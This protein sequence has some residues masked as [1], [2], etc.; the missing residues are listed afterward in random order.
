MGKQV[1]EIIRLITIAKDP[2]K[3]QEE[4]LAAARDCS[5]VIAS[6]GVGEPTITLAKAVLSRVVDDCKASVRATDHFSDFGYWRRFPLNS[7]NKLDDANALRH[8]T[9]LTCA[10]L[11]WDGGRHLEAVNFFDRVLEGQPTASAVILACWNMEVLARQQ[12]SIQ[13]VERALDLLTSRFKRILDD[14]QYEA[15]V[16]HLSG[17]LLL[18]RGRFSKNE[19]LGYEKLGVQRLAYA[20]SLW[21]AYSACYASSFAEYGDFLASVE[22]C[23]ELIR[24][25]PFDD[26]PKRDARIVELE[27]LFY[28]A[29]GLMAAGEIE[30]ARMC[31]RTFSSVSGQLG[32]NEARDHAR[33]FLFKLDLKGRSLLELHDYELEKAYEELRSLSF[34]ATLSL[35]VSEECIRYESILLFLLAL[36]RARGIPQISES[37]IQ[38]LGQRSVEILNQLQLARKGILD[39]IQ[40]R[41]GPAN[42]YPE[43]VDNVIASIHIRTD[44]VGD[45]QIERYAAPDIPNFRGG[46]SQNSILMWGVAELQHEA[47]ATMA[48]D[49]IPFAASEALIEG[50]P[51]IASAVDLLLISLAVIGIRRFWAEDRYVFGLVPC[52]E[53]PS[54]K[55][56]HPYYDV[57]TVL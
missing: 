54:T 30:R 9:A 56:Q 43:A 52:L 55:F 42:L 36:T 16:A 12:E 45:L 28:L 24:S 22:T 31:F 4:R 40:V 21:S 17:H 25:R 33:L 18:L 15:E 6:S 39:G 44:A 57:G 7:E 32:F 38:Q 26:L 35:P 8:D 5:W 51:Q 27:I 37:I 34:A 3:S 14:S 13:I 53:S 50:V 2:Q 41:V 48:M 29:Y 47:A 23:L 49:I 19:S 10:Q 20:T 46:E 1:Q 11:L